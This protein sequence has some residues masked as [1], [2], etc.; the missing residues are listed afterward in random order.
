M[1]PVPH[2]KGNLEYWGHVSHRKQVNEQL[3]K[4]WERKDKNARGNKD[5]LSHSLQHLVVPVQKLD[6]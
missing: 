6:T 1:K 4:M 3:C 2:I 5:I